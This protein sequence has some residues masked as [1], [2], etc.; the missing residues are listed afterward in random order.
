MNHQL[1]KL[2]LRSHDI[3]ADKKAELLRLFPEI[4]T[5]DGKIDFK[6]LKLMLGETV[7]VGKEKK[8]GRESFLDRAGLDAID[9]MAKCR[10]DLDLQLVASHTMS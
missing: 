3:A 8:R 7:D 1:E 2:D 6:R 10:D 9:A 4:R 5:E